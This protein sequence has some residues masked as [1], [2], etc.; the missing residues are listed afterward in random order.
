MEKF[1]EPRDLK[2]VKISE[3]RW[4]LPEFMIDWNSN[5]INRNIIIHVFIKKEELDI[6]CNAWHDE[7]K[8]LDMKPVLERFWTNKKIKT[9]DFLNQFEKNDDYILTIISILRDAYITVS[10]FKKKA[11]KNKTIIPINYFP[12]SL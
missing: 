9:I 12:Q 7:Y 10:A 3:W 5:L 8:Y 4:D 1:I 11:L 2:N 6:E